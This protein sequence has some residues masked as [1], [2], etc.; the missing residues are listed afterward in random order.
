[1]NRRG[2]PKKLLEGG[3]LLCPTTGLDQ[4]G[5]LLIS[6]EGI[7][8]IFE[9]GASRPP[10]SSDVEI[11]DVKGCMVLPGLIESQLPLGGARG[12]RESLRQ[13]LQ[14]ALRGGFSTVLALPEGKSVVEAPKVVRE[15]LRQGDEEGLA[16]LQVAAAFALHESDGRALTDLS[17]LAAAGA[18]AFSDRLTAPARPLLIRHALK[19]A[20]H[21]KRAV[22]LHA[23][24][25][26]LSPAGVV[27]E[28][29]ASDRLGL[30]GVPEAAETIA[31]FQAVEMARLSG[32]RV[33]LPLLSTGRAVE[34][35]LDAREKGLPI[36]AGVSPWHLLFDE[37]DVLEN[38]FDS[39]FR[40]WPPLRRPGDREALI[41]AVKEGHLAI[42]ADHRPLDAL[43]RD[44][45]FAEAA[46]GATGFAT[47]LVSLWAHFSPSQLARAFSSIPAGILGL[48]DR[49]AIA[50][51][52]RADLVVVDP[53]ETWEMQPENLPGSFS[54]TPLSGQ[55][56][57]AVI[58]STWVA[59]THHPGWSNQKV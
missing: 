59:G 33:H 45:P 28:G 26:D 18:M 14:M 19:T 54:N 50:P 29:P 1:M 39:R 49:G 53:R 34:I 27:G 38:A 37:N 55:A 2:G 3:H 30:P 44:F 5:D 10:L 36:S 11:V 25:P 41:H 57:G 46:P 52:R 43:N 9:K 7:E 23:H 17:D 13:T 6:A 42:S 16:D 35:V 48:D 40:L 47:A 21:L 24:S 32:A 58:R 4:V 12:R 56:A 51:G 31:V 20:A 15:L 22:I 8:A